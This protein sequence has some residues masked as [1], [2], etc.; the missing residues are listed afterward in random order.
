LTYFTEIKWDAERGG[1]VVK[2]D[3]D[4]LAS[5]VGIR[6][7]DELLAIN[8]N[9]LNDV[10]DVNFYGAEEYLEFF[11][12]RGGEYQVVEAER[13]YGQSLGIEFEHPTFDTDILRCNNLCEF[14]FVLQ[15]APRFR[16]TLYIKDDDYRY[17]FLFGHFVTLTNLSD[18]DWWRIETMGLSP[19]YVSVHVTDLTMRRRFLRNDQA[20][21]ILE[22]LTWLSEKGIKI[23]T[24]IVVVPEFNDGEWLRRSVREL[25]SLWPSVRSISVVPV[26][27]TRFHKYGMRTHTIDES[28][29]MLDELE[30]MQKDHRDR[31]GINFA[32]PTDEWYLVAGM[33][34]PPKEAYDDQKLQENGLGMVRDFLDEW[35]ALRIEI[36][37]DTNINGGKNGATGSV[38]P[39]AVTLVTG[40]LFSETLSE[41]GVEFRKLTGIEVTVH[42][43]TNR[44]LGRTITVA[45]LLNA[46]D[47]IEH[48]AKTGYGSLV[49]LPLK[50]FDHPD[51]ISLDDY[52]P[53]QVADRLQVDV[54]LAESMGDVWDAVK[55]NSSL[56]YTPSG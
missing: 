7:G 25:S 29:M 55:G 33:A 48:L 31:F 6:P 23:H 38:S 37:A 42:G 27:L 9:Q 49:V 46:A 19:L 52:T 30:G 34:I 8:R 28:R 36:G 39:P 51:R 44:A 14:C 15:M 40:T 21:D 26:G 22:Q 56:F 20:P 10:I 11:I 12:R 43:V 16:R 41:I 1:Q 5:Q 50:A 18:H 13:E 17:S 53:Q 4:G 35:E 3:E 47:I 45:G 54:A 32:Y 24:Q 2:V